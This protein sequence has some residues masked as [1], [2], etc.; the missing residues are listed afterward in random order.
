MFCNAE[1]ET[2]LR[3]EGLPEKEYCSDECSLNDEFDEYGA[4]TFEKFQKGPKDQWH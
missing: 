4:E 3:W 1:F 2:T